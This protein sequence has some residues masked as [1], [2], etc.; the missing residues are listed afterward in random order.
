V[1]ADGSGDYPTIQAAIDDANN[2]D[3]IVCADGTY[4]GAGNRDIDFLGKA[5]TVRSENGP[6]NCIIDCNGTEDE[7]HRGF[8]FHSGEDANSIVDGFTI[9]NGY[10]VQGGGI[11]CYYSSPT[12]TNCTISHN[13]TSGWSDGGGI[14]CQHSNPIIANCTVSNNTTNGNGG[15]ISCYRYNKPIIR[16]CNIYNNSATHGGGGG[17]SSN[18]SEPQIINCTI[19]NNM[20]RYGAGIFGDH[21]EESPT[22]S[23]CI[24]S[25]NASDYNAGG[26]I[27]GCNGPITNCII[28]DNTGVYPG[29]GGLNRC[30]GPI[31]N[32]IITNNSVSNGW[33]GGMYRCNGPITNCIIADNWASKDGGGI[34]VTS[35][36]NTITNCTIISNTA[37][38]YGGGIYG[39]FG[40]NVA[41]RNCVLWNNVAASGPEICLDYDQ[42]GRPCTLT[43]SY[44]DID[45][46]KA[47]AHIDSTCTLIWGVGNIDANPRFVSAGGGNLHLRPDSPCIDAGDP[48]YSAGPNETDLDGNPRIFGDRVDM[49]A[50]EFTILNTE[51]VVCIVGGD[52][53]VEAGG[54][55]QARITLDGSCSSDADSTEGTNDDINDFDWYEVID[56]CE[57]NSDIYLGS[58]EVIE[59]NLGLGEHV[60]ILE[61]TDKAGAFD[62]N[63]VVITVEDVTPPELSVVVEPNTLWPPNGKMVQVRTE[64]EVSDNC[65]EEVEVSLADISMNAAGDINDYVHIGDDGSIYLRARKSKGGSGRIYTLTYEAVDDSGNVTEASATVTVPHRKGR[66]RLGRG[67]V[68]RPGRQVYRRGVRR[69]GAKE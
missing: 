37:L 23:N 41:I 58:G 38:G 30:N 66:R 56:A 26:G 44:S 55:C 67:L 20:A 3:E 61:V 59:C 27:Q 64:W 40:S 18:K 9:R 60:I 53:V 21:D 19:N 29:G 5:V 57:P 46:G 45:G 11:R 33:G 2:G 22:I 49:G 63:E 13:R 1:Q 24:I 36:G 28:T 48:N 12:I 42:Y 10:V 62:S 50:Y 4:T 25:G 47:Y 15:G 17:I 14:F 69:R 52:G 8:H 43:I 32:C 16:D 34:D 35:C 7:P 6:E 68:R 54:D 31:A 39:W 65:D 51:P